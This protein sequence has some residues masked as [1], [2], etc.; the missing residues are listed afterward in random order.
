VEEEIFEVGI[1]C[2]VGHSFAVRN[3]FAVIECRLEFVTDRNEFR[4]GTAENLVI[5]VMPR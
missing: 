5:I 3:F 2:N 4:V 1:V